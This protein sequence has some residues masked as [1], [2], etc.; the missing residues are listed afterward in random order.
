[1]GVKGLISA[2][3]SIARQSSFSSKCALHTRLVRWV[4]ERHGTVKSL[5]IIQTNCIQSCHLWRWFF[6][7]WELGK[8]STFICTCS[9]APINNVPIGYFEN[10]SIKHI[11]LVKIESST[12]ELNG[13]SSPH[14]RMWRQVD[15]ES[16]DQKVSFKFHVP[17]G[18]LIFDGQ[19][20]QNQRSADFIFQI[21]MTLIIRVIWVFSFQFQELLNITRGAF[22]LV[23]CFLF[24][25]FLSFFLFFF[26][27]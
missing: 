10:N 16:R 5:L 20:R 27:W 18:R 3:Y 22:N 1:M 9:T 14:C 17:Y 24:P 15:L 13:I 2:C 23:F 7:L 8:T 25:L 21:K 4:W 19:I 26:N 6:L 12:T 11:K